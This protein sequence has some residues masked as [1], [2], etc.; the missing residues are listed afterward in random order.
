MISVGVLGNDRL[1][2][3]PIAS[4]TSSSGHV[5]CPASIDEQQAQHY[6]SLALRAFRSV[7]CRDFARVDMMIDRQGQA[8]VVGIHTNTILD[9]RGPMAVMA[10]AAGLTWP[11][12]MG[13]IV[14]LAG[15]RCGVDWDSTS[16]AI[17]A[18][19]TTAT[20]VVMGT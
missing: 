1:T 20:P 17:V 6:R 18:T 11:Q 2:C 7:G 8:Y 19:T 12:L 10:Q 14:E 15:A 16:Q 13:T 5:D 4:Q 3:L 9:K